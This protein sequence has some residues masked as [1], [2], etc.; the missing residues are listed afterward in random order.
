MCDITRSYSNTEAIAKDRV[1]DTSNTELNIVTLKHSHHNEVCY[2]LPMSKRVYE[3]YISMYCTVREL[4]STN[5]N[6][7]P[8]KF[9]GINVNGVPGGR[10]STESMQDRWR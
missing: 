4:A 5:T 7:N 10:A 3:F 1:A 6:H 9:L 8:T 2:S